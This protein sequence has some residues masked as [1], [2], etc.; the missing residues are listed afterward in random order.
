M[1]AAGAY[2]FLLV[3]MVQTESTNINNNFGNILT[4]VW[5]SNPP[6]PPPA[7]CANCGSKATF[8]ALCSL[9]RSFIYTYCIYTILCTFYRNHF[10]VCLTSLASVRKVKDCTQRETMPGAL[11]LGPSLSLSF[12]KCRHKSY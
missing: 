10:G 1:T 8:N 7:Y 9:F 2:N 3:C 6:L 12:S 5:T 4:H 11:V